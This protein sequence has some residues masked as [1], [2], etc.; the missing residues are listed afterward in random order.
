[1][2]TQEKAFIR[3]C[4]RINYHQ[5]TVSKKI[6]HVFINQ[7]TFFSDSY[8]EFLDLSQSDHAPCLIQHLLS[9]RQRVRKPFK[10][11]HHI[12]DHPEYQN[13]VA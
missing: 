6:D 10:F 4:I 5:N 11:F 9:A 7:D 1:M 8:A 2:P 13:S 12:I 3:S